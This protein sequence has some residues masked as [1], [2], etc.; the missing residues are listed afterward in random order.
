MPSPTASVQPPARL[1][2]ILRLAL[3]ALAVA[4]GAVLF[5]QYRQRFDI[6]ELAARETQLR[7]AVETQP[8]AAL[9]IAFVAYVAV[10]G[11]SLPGA[12]AM[13]VCCG[14]LFGFWRALVLV[15]FAS[16]TG[17]TLA[18]LLCRY[19]LGDW[20][21]AR[22]GERLRAINAAIDREGAFYLFT[23]R[24]IPQVP[25]FVVNAAMGLTRIRVWTFWWV[26][27]LGMLPG[28]IV[29][30]FAGSS[31]PSLKT[32]A[33]RGLGSVVDWRLFAALALLSLAPLVIK[34]IIG[35]ADRRRQM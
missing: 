8:V 2:M 35:W 29:F 21:Q 33:E 18:F 27:Q 16:T 17:A 25:F 26:S 22:Y 30:V 11:L 28:T 7:Q 20:I 14:W 6:H 5:L 19:L 24:L 31:V 34:R 4:A 13:S 3:L 12:A 9:A 1:G 10:T 32:V 15:S 23:L